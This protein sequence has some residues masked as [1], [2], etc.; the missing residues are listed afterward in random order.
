MDSFSQA[1]FLP[2]TGGFRK[3][4]ADVGALSVA[5]I[6]TA[7]RKAP[8]ARRRQNPRCGPWFS[9]KYAFGPRLGRR[10]IRVALRARARGAVGASVELWT[11]ARSMELQL[12]SRGER[13]EPLLIPRKRRTLSPDRRAAAP[14]HATAPTPDTQPAAFVRPTRS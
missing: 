11:V 3:G 13:N 5:R 7:A 14:L 12:A 6:A 8:Q 10:Q 1:Y 2:K 4:V 9:S